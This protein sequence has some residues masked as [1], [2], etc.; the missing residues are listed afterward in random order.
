MEQG[1]REEAVDQHLGKQIN[2]TGREERHFY[3]HV[4]QMRVACY[5]QIGLG[6]QACTTIPGVILPAND[7]GA[8]PAGGSTHL[9][10]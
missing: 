6:L 7:L 3:L 4:Q 10:I 9:V 5:R 2:N 8:L 1:Q